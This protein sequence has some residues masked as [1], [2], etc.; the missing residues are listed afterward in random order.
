MA[1]TTLNGVI[2]NLAQPIQILKNSPTPVA[3]RLTTLFYQAGN[4]AGA[5]VSTA[6]VAGEALTAY[7][8]QLPFTNSDTK[9]TY[10]GRFSASIY[11][12]ALSTMG[13]LFLCD[14]LWHNSG[15][16]TNTTSPQTVNSV[17]YPARDINQSVN[18]E[19]I[20]L[21]V[22]ITSVFAATACILSIT[23]TS[24]TD[25]AATT[26]ISLPASAAAFGFFPVPLVSGHTGVKAIGTVTSSAIVATGAYSLV[27]YRVISS[28]D[29]QTAGKTNSVDAFT[30]GFPRLFNNSVPFLL[31]YPESANGTPVVSAQ[32]TYTQG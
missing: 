16:L 31:L 12:A 13:T 6:G 19:G 25:V 14:R 8:G 27:A 18:G 20:F 21:G 2:N 9:N 3:N 10:L 22:E 30:S 24:S 17:T 7:T 26:T 29:M 23:Y 28:V 32:L 11:S 4:P 15:L 5:S 1:I